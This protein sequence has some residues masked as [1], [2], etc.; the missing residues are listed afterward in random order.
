MSSTTSRLGAIHALM[1]PVRDQERALE[2]YVDTLGWE[3]RS[4]VAFGE[5]DRWIEVAP[6]GGEAVVALVP[7]R[8]IEKA[9]FAV[10]T[11]DID[12]THAHYHELGLNVG[13]VMRMGGPV[14]P[15]FELDDPDGNIIWVVGAPEA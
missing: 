12:A 5:G 14:P 13:D 1:L 10:T 7:P 15:M 11:A 2:F 4:D 9:A 3:K 6:A 8:G